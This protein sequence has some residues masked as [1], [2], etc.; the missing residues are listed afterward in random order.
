MKA[1]PGGRWAVIGTDSGAVEA[2]DREHRLTV[3]RRGRR[4]RQQPAAQLAIRA[5]LSDLQRTALRTAHRQRRSVPGVARDT[6]SSAIQPVLLVTT[7]TVLTG[8]ITWTRAPFAAAHVDAFE[9]GSRFTGTAT[10]VIVQRQLGI[11]WS[12][13]APDVREVTQNF[14]STFT[15]TVTPAQVASAATR[16]A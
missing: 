11:A 2:S 4:L 10:G 12:T 14:T 1:E 13:E 5:E 3:V 8:R 9:T 15:I 6:T 16:T 7:P